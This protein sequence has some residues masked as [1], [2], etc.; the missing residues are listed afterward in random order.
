MLF[1]ELETER[2]FLKNISADDREFILDH[3]S[4]GAIN[5][6]LYDAEPLADLQEADEIIAFYL[7]PEPRAQHRWILTTKDGR[8][9]GTCGFHCWN[10][11]DGSCDIGYDLNPEFWGKGYMDEALKAILAFARKEMKLK[12][13]NACIYPD[14]EKSVKLA[15]KAGFRYQGK[16]ESLSFGGKVYLHKIYHLE[17]GNPSISDS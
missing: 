1:R 13:V 17:F 14:N 5:Q 7:Q 8:K 3:F 11:S 10:T 6:Y 12:K 9:I 4:N 16:T 2:L 15:E